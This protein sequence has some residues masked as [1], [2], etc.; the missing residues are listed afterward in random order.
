MFSQ[1]AHLALIED[2]LRLVDLSPE[3]SQD[4][5]TVLRQ[6]REI[7]EIGVISDLPAF[8]RWFER[9]RDGW[10]ARKPE[11]LV[12]KKLAYIVGCLLNKAAEEAI[13]SRLDDRE[14]AL[15]RD[16][17]VF[18]ETASRGDAAAP[19]PADVELFF[20]V[21]AIRGIIALHTFQPGLDGGDWSKRLIRLWEDFYARLPH[22]S[23]ALVAPDPEH[24]KQYVVDAGFYVPDDALIQLLRRVQHGRPVGWE[25]VAPA[26]RGA[27]TQSAY[28]RGVKA[29][30][31][32]LVAAD[33]FFHAKISK[34]QLLVVVGIP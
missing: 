30:Y 8:I 21:L 24:V 26:L 31:D 10:A 33:R 34:Q 13:P 3:V 1:I 28:A 17:Y 9:L 25:E 6:E 32:S 2:V 4:V 7:A 18:R 29:G 22:F 27:A 16:A 5:K 20:K 23:Q 15:C 14:C 12:E 19:S 11:E